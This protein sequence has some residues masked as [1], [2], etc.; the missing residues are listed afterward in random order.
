MGSVPLMC[1]TDMC[2]TNMVQACYR[3]DTDAIQ[4][5]RADLMHRAEIAALVTWGA[6]GGQG[7]DGRRSIS[8][9]MVAQ[10]IVPGDLQG[11]GGIQV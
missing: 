3:C 4:Q 1:N 9:V 2:S 6:M 8:V 11:R 5:L 7:I 10:H